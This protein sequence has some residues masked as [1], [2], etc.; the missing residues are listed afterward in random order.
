MGHTLFQASK[1]G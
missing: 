1:P